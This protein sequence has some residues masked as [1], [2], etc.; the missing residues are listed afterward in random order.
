MNEWMNEWKNEY[1]ISNDVNDDILGDGIV[2][3]DL[4]DDD[5]ALRIGLWRK[6]KK[7]FLKKINY[8]SCFIIKMSFS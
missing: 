4:E 1:Q 8:H 7:I 6:R 3:V 5:I 2:A